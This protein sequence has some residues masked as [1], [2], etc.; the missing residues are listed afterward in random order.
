V[1]SPTVIRTIQGMDLS[2][3]GIVIHKLAQE[4]AMQR[5]ME[6]A[7]M[8]RD[9]LQAGRQAPAIAI[10]RPAQFILQ[11]KM[12]TLDSELRSLSFDAQ[13]RKQMMSETLLN[14]MDYSSTQK[15]RAFDVGVIHNPQP[16]LENSALPIKTNKN[17]DR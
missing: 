12:T 17:G 9:I 5:V 13:V 10:N 3:Q 16:V 14:L 4:V 11:D 6:K 15:D 1:I 2:Q 8:A 7:L